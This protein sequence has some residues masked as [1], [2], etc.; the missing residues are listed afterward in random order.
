MSEEIEFLKEE[1]VLP[2]EIDTMSW[3]EAWMMTL[4][5]PKIENFRKIIA[6]PNMKLRWNYFWWFFLSLFFLI[7]LFVIDMGFQHSLVFSTL[8]GL[9][10]MSFPLAGFSV[11]GFMVYVVFIQW[12]A[13]LYGGTGSYK[14]LFYLLS[15]VYIF[16]ASLIAS[17]STIAM[18][19]GSASLSKWAG[20]FSAVL[21]AYIFILTVF[22]ISAANSLDLRK[23]ITVT[24]VPFVLVSF[25]VPSLFYILLI[26]AFL[27][28]IK[29]KKDDRK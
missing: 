17:M 5:I 1:S 12:A 29:R 14:K 6:Q 8:F 27:V 25:F 19:S 18:W 28:F 2:S 24:F 26:G 21:F 16:P 7:I 15:M 10:G 9:I 11:L 23:S 20:I 13:K 4:P 22:S 3:Y